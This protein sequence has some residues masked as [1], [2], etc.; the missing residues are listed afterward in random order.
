MSQ[1]N[2]S[3]VHYFLTFLNLF[4]VF[5][6]FI[7]SIALISRVLGAG[8]E[9]GTC[10]SMLYLTTTFLSTRNIETN[11]GWPVAT[12]RS[13]SDQV[14]TPFNA[15][16]SSDRS[17]RFGHYLECMYT[18][19]MADK[20]C[21]PTLTYNEYVYCLTNTTGVVSG[22]DAC[23]SFPTVASVYSHWPTSEEYLGCLWN[24]PLLQ[25]SESQRASKNVFRACIDK[26]LW[27]FFEV[28]QTIDSPVIFGSYNWALLLVSGLIVMTSFGVYT[29][30][31]WEEGQV[32]RGEGGYFMRLG[33]LWSALAFFWNLFFL[34]IF[35]IIA[36]RNT[37]EFQKG[38][39]LPTTVSTM[40]VTLLV[41]AVATFY[42]FAA[43]MQGIRPKKFLSVIT[44]ENMVK[45]VPVCGN[46]PVDDTENQRL[47][48]AGT[49]PAIDPKSGAHSNKYKLAEPDD[50]ARYYTPP[51]LAVWSDSYFAD[52][53]IVLGMAGAT[54]Q[55]STDQAWNLAT[56]TIAYR[57]LNMIISRCISDAF[58]NNVRLSGEVN[59]AKNGI[60]TRP[61]MF[62]KY[63]KVPH[64]DPDTTWKTRGDD[65][66]KSTHNMDV[67]LNTRI[68]GL[69]TQLA[70]LY[71]YVGLMVLVFSANSALNDFDIFKSFFIVCF[72]VP[73]GL[74]LLL[75]LFYQFAVT[76]G[77]D[78]VPWM[79]YNAG[80][81]IWLWDYIARIIFVCIVIFDG[82]NKPGTFD[83]LKI[84]T[85]ALMRDYPS[86]LAF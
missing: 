80:F 46:H 29:A 14:Q 32:T 65:Y 7:L 45:I 1:S 76:E 34:I 56:L 63:S 82:G 21:P 61:S 31:P 28:P 77:N 67:H 54:G 33:A 62:F 43:A 35:V 26:S 8:C 71:L 75:H 74:R 6:G 50:V 49:F 18:A 59:K 79:L 78:G 9:E 27:P 5:A 69:S 48:L 24:N 3:G 53:C 40:F 30:S 23:A 41:Y 2:N 44:G 66:G 72:V 68:I 52:V 73:E 86:A 39:G 37:G 51:L 60:V 20:A 13:F 42:F 25:N 58:M 85:N 55:L 70:A 19:R 36:F 22:L 4:A 15:A 38:G 11:I 47:L 81:I 12:E 83:F 84:Q 64:H 10:Q 57:I 16:A 17:Y